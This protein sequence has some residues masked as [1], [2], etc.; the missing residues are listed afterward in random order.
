M[1]QN[2]I[3]INQKEILNKFECYVNRY[4]LAD[5]QIHLKVEHSY[6]VTQTSHTNKVC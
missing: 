6:K 2:K 5:K 1:T 3:T 4:N